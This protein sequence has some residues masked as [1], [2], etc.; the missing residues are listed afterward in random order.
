MM[1]AIAK[2]KS[3]IRAEFIKICEDAINIIERGK[4]IRTWA[5]PIVFFLKL[6]ADFY[7]YLC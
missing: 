1:S 6:R 3:N 7:R 4:V 5:E 2:Y